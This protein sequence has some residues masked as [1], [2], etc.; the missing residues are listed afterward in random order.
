MH[1][2]KKRVVSEEKRWGFFTRPPVQR[3]FSQKRGEGDCAIE[4]VKTMTPT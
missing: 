1:K 4:A 2:E 3:L